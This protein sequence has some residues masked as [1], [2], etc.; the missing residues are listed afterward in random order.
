M[1]RLGE[2][3][4]MLCAE[5]PLRRSQRLSNVRVIPRCQ[6]ASRRISED[7]NVLRRHEALRQQ[8]DHAARTRVPGPIDD[9]HGVSR[10]AAL[11][12]NISRTNIL[13]AGSLPHLA[14]E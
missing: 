12:E 13:P 11:N 4:K 6:R 14:A 9:D 3:P 1:P 5:S 8:E 10:I 7:V 2:A